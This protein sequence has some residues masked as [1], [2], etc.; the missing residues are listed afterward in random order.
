M[1]MNDPLGDMLRIDVSLP[2]DTFLIPADNPYATAALDTLP[3][4]WAN[5]LRNPWRFGFD[6]LTG[7]LW[8]GDVGQGDWEEI[9]FWPAG[10]NSGPN[11]G[12]RCYEG[13]APYNTGG[14]G[15]AWEE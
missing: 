7:D 5:G 6:A 8:I 11:F 9:D 12:W 14:C 1:L 2:G 4:I 10:D 15:P 13:L 3:E